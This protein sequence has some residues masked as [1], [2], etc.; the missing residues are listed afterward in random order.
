MIY[1]MGPWDGT[2]DPPD[3]ENT[4]AVHLEQ[5]ADTFRLLVGGALD[6]WLEKEVQ[7][8]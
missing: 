8:E 6:D 7:N 3:P 1:S 2:V 4:L 5:Q